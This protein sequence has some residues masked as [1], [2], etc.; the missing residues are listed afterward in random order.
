PAFNTLGGEAHWLIE[1]HE[2]LR[3]GA[4][5]VESNRL[6][7]AAATADVI[8]AIRQAAAAGLQGPAGAPARSE[9]RLLEKTPK[10]SLR[11]AFL[12]RVFPDA[13][14]IFLWRDPRENVSSIMEA[15]RS[16]NWVTYPALPDW[17]G[18]WSLLLPPGWKTLRGAQ[19]EAVAAQQWLQA[20]EIALQDLRQLPT[21]RWT[22]VA[23]Q[24]F[25]ADPAATIRRICAFLD[26]P[27]DAALQART[28]AALPLSR[29]TLTP[30]APEKWRINAAAIERVLPTLE[31]CWQILRKQ[32]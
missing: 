15:W 30:P 14:F 16:G 5:G 22:T 21:D 31:S 8:T 23:F 29:Y 25:V 1:G 4:A 27:F 26:V 28:A 19:L 9:A 17:D 24:D 6:E 13:Q 32:R 3:P 10:N 11:I 2:S 12:Q 20:N 7:A 18:P